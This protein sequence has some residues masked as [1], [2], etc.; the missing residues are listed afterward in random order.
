MAELSK[1]RKNGVDY[2]LKD[3]EARRIG[4][5]FANWG[6]PIL[7]LNGDTTG[8]NKDNSVDLAY[9]YGERSGTASVKW[10]G[11]S[12]IYYP[13]K[14]FTVKFD[15]AFEAKEGWGAQKKY[16]LK[17][18][19]I[20]ASHSRNVVNAK[21]WGQIVASRK[22]AN[23]TLAACPNYGAVD[24]FPCIIVLNGE[25]YGLYTFNIP[26]DAW[27]ANMGNGN[28]ECILCA[29][30]QGQSCKFKA[31]A[32]LDGDF[33]VEY[34]TDENDTE[35]AKTSLNELINACILS[36][37]SDIDTTIASMC[38][39]QSAI[40]YLCFTVFVTGL[41]MCGK[42]Y[43]LFK[44]DNEPWTF[45]AYDMDC[46]YSLSW[47]GAE[48]GSALANP[49]VAYFASY[50]RL[51]G[52]IV[53]YKAN[54]FKARWKELRGS[55]L[56]EDNIQKMF[57]NFAG[58]IPKVAKNA[59]VEKWPTIPNS[60]TNTV[61]QIFENLKLRL[62]MLDAEIE[63]L[64]QMDIVDAPM[65]AAGPAWFNAESAGIEQSAVTSVA[66]D[67]TYA[68][69][70]EESA[71]WGCDVNG[72]GTIMA[73]LN[74]TDITIKPTTG[75]TR[76]RLNPN[77]NG[78]FANDGTN[79]SFS[80]LASVTGTECWVANEGTTMV[81]LLMN[82][83][84]ITEPICIPEGVTAINNI[85]SSCSALL[86]APVIP[87]SVTALDNAFL[88][89]NALTEMP[90]IPSM[91]NNLY[92]FVGNCLA[93]TD[94]NIVVPESVKNMERAFWNCKKMNGNIEVNASNLQLYEKC[95]LNTC[96][97]SGAVT[98]TGSCP[99]LAEL[100]ATNTDGKVTVLE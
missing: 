39:I 48:F 26:K 4:R 86:H 27:M 73:Y 89:C 12:S 17:A 8:M 93:I 71:S 69:T 57:L 55:I 13:K 66:F 58:A 40:D 47:N 20:D 14:N 79:A 42:N 90:N 18:N 10:Q 28:Q 54:A 96:M 9:V 19:W 33:E 46:T 56:S 99:L 67:A 92:Y 77:S 100:A 65:L 98:L 23:A 87:E 16:V 11:S 68:E 59:E 49:T 78:M 70:G 76:I 74:G 7:Y 36:N 2:N 91:A 80:S 75:A 31:E 85:F 38:D 84:L 81:K 44:R 63:A 41:D 60:D 61:Y 37:G 6:M 82:N 21:L 51:M 22:P 45:G 88:S 95:F 30:D 1:I 83:N 62:P 72:A 15:T 64:V 24:G 34:A 32:T 3:T 35:W 94:V 29:D 53:S 50:H 5:N 97:T 25:F 52:L 43:L